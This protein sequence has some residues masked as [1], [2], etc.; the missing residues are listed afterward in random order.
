ME[1]A[2]I[3]SNGSES[4][5]IEYERELIRSAMCSEISDSDKYKLVEA[6][7]GKLSKREIA[8]LIYVI[9]KT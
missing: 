9:E 6:I 4:E 5:L 8:N 1:L 3:L 2:N 7:V